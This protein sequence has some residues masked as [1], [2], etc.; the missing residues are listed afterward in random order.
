[1]IHPFM[2]EKTVTGPIRLSGV[3]YDSLADG[4]GVRVALYF[5]GCKHHCPGCH[6]PSTHNFSAGWI[7]T[8][9]EL[10]EIVAEINKRPYLSGITLTG[11]DPLYRPYQLNACVEYILKRVERPLTVW[12]YTGFCWED[13]IYHEDVMR[14]IDVVVD[15]PFIQEQAD[16]RL[17]YKGSLNQR[18]IDVK[19]SLAAGEVVL[20]AAV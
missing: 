13:G 19:K 20:Y 8:S 6:N 10:D 5:S 17:V 15:G 18:I 1:M 11:G 16:K 12:L 4:E 7:V 9:Q 14:H 3:L 2:M